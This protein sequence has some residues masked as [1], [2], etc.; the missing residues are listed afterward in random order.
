M[1][2]VLPAAHS[3]DITGG[4]FLQDRNISGGNQIGL[5]INFSKTLDKKG[6]PTLGTWVTDPNIYSGANYFNQGS[7][8]IQIK[9]AKSG[10]A[11]VIFRGHI[12]TNGITDILANAS[13]Y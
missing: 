5:D 2:I 12:Y 9:Y 4:A 11:T 1:A 6:R 7:G 3:G 8:T 10:V 13:K